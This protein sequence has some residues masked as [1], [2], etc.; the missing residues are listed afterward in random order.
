VRQRVD[1]AAVGTVGD[2]PPVLGIMGTRVMAR[3]MV[4]AVEVSEAGCLVAS[5]AFLSGD[6]WGTAAGGDAAAVLITSHA[7]TLVSRC[8]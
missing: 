2:I 3:A 5:A 7:S 4:T 1:S 6:R 8:C